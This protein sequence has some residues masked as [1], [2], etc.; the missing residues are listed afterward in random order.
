MCMIMIMGGYL[1]GKGLI[2]CTFNVFI[3]C[4]LFIIVFITTFS[5]YSVTPP[6]PLLFLS[7]Y[8]QSLHSSFLFSSLDGVRSVYLPS[9]SRCNL[10]QVHPAIHSQNAP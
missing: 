8:I 6:P 1:N 2:T 9:N 10:H 3:L 5:S 7:P 4:V